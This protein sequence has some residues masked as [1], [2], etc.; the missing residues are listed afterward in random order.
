MKFKNIF[1]S[2]EKT[3]GAFLLKDYT[4]TSTNIWEYLFHHA[5]SHVLLS[6]HVDQKNEWW[7]RENLDQTKEIRF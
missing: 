6:I 2:V 7:P 4:Y 3:Q 5:L 1:K